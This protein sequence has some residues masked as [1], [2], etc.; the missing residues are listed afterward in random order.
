MAETDCV[1]RYFSILQFMNRFKLRIKWNSCALNKVK[2]NSI[3]CHSLYLL[4][5]AVLFSIFAIWFIEYRLHTVS[6]NNVL[7]ALENV[8]RVWNDSS[9]D[10]S[11]KL[12]LDYV[13]FTNYKTPH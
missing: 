7:I 11:T 12:F 10:V 5:I 13:F 8:S 1:L 3:F 9:F 2:S 6:H 4:P